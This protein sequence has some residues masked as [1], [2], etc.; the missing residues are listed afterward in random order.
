MFIQ[1]LKYAIH[2]HF[3][4]RNTTN[5]NQIH[6]RHSSTIGSANLM[7]RLVNMVMNHEMDHLLGPLFDPT[8]VLILRRINN[9]LYKIVRTD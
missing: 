6:R 8:K 7:N 5:H 4:D 9:G 2:A 1:M 3:D